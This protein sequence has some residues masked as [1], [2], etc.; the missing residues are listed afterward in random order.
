[1]HAQN[2]NVPIKIARQCFCQA[3][4]PSGKRTH[5]GIKIRSALYVP[6]K[7]LQRFSLRM[8]KLAA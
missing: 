2:C 1:M 3:V 5:T 4:Y 8:R 7:T 6:I